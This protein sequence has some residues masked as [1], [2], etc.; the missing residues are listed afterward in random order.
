M[1]ESSYFIDIN[2]YPDID[3]HTLLEK[4]GINS[5]RNLN[6]IRLEDIR[7]GKSSEFI[8]F[9]YPYRLQQ[10]SQDCGQQQKD[11]VD[12]TSLSAATLSA[13]INGKSEARICSLA[14]LAGHF[15]VSA[16][17]LLGLTD[18]KAV[19]PDKKS[20]C[21]YTRLSDEAAEALNTISKSKDHPLVIS[22]L[23]FLLETDMLIDIAVLLERAII[24]SKQYEELYGSSDSE[25]N[26]DQIES[27]EYQFN[28]KLSGMFTSILNDYYKAN[29]DRVDTL[30]LDRWEELQDAA[31]ETKEKMED[32]LERYTEQNAMALYDLIKK[33][34]PAP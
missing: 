17:Y 4:S 25:I 11:I 29:K 31:I 28:K 6:K 26:N 5:E 20:T 12:E 33:S 1:R 10:L 16:D 23:S 9:I 19:L 2:N 30:V 15:N 27:L 13:Q 34:P 7:S 8:R 14:Q 18:I 22:I 24:T 3:Y 32:I 21:E